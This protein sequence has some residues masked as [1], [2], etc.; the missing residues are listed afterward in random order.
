MYPNANEHSV[1]MDYTSIIG[2]IQPKS[3]KNFQSCRFAMTTDDLLKEDIQVPEKFSKTQVKRLKIILP[4]LLNKFGPKLVRE[5]ELYSVE[6]RKIFGEEKMGEHLGKLLLIVV[7]NTWDYKTEGNTKCKTYRLNVVN[8]KK[9]VPMIYGSEEKV[10]D[11][12]IGSI[13]NSLEEELKTGNFSYTTKDFRQYHPLISMPKEYRNKVLKDAGYIHEY[14]I[15]SCAPTII[16]ERAKK[17]GAKIPFNK[18][19]DRFVKNPKRYRDYIAK[20]SGVSPKEVK[21]TINAL[22]HG[23]RMSTKSEIYTEIL[24]CSMPK[25]VRLVANPRFLKFR[26]AMGRILSQLSG[27]VENGEAMSFGKRTFMLYTEI[28][29][30]IRKIWLE[31]AQLK[32]AK[33]FLIHDGFNCDVEIDEQTIMNKIKDEIGYC[34]IIER[35]V[36]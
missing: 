31:L 24:G 29:Q 30:K 27:E 5:Q 12:V 13:R 32:G 2:E 23:S 1:F 25:F 19:V 28:E 34:V 26:R 20:R 35:G 8:Y 16:I 17:S 15:A 7:D 33:I 14:D 36:L 10:E 3:R 4:Y 18:E 9:I 21:Q 22:I 11:E 6:L